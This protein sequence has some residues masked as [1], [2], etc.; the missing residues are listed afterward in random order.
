MS[1]AAPDL[2][3]KSD[4]GPRSGGG[5]LRALVVCL[6]IA[7]IAVTW[8]VGRELTALGGDLHLAGGYVLVGRFG[9]V[10]SARVLLSLAVASGVILQGPSLAARLRWPSVL[11]GSGIVAASWA[12]ALAVSSGSG[13]LAK[14]MT[15]KYDYLHDVGRVSGIGS[16]LSTF[17]GSVPASSAHPWVTH[18]AGHPPG[19]LLA[20]V[21]IDRLGLSGAGWAAAMCIAGGALAVPAVLV[22][23][24]AVADE[25]AAR[26]MAPFAVLAPAALWVATSADALF[27]GV[28]A[29]GIA[30]LA[31]AA[32]RGPGVPG[33]LRAV[34]GGLLLG[35]A[36]FLSF[37]LT[38]LG[39]VAL[40]VVLAHRQRLGRAGVIRLLAVAGLGVAVIF[41]IFA[42]GGYSWFAGIA[43]DAQ[44]VRDGAAYPDRPYAYFLVANVA[45]AAVAAGP[46]VVAGL[47]GLR[48]Q[49]LRWVPCAALGAMALSDVSGLVLGE[50]ERIWLPFV[51]FLFPATATIPLGSRRLWL[52]L[53]AV[54][55]I[56]VE[57]TVRTPW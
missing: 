21:L 15:T 18:V 36:L 17:V 31:Q 28:A 10:L 57:V 54:L 20:F 44:R 12:V 2:V 27:A 34:G 32:A 33:Y 19:A 49:R 24:R 7:G 37:G 38:A 39:L 48:R 52:A 25:A 26:A 41:A 11:V 40:A 30:L 51:V 16:F 47:A 5:R 56:V 46:A 35:M 43:V 8:L 3:R 9:V 23:V 50:T 1:T 42:A 6:V 14:P 4:V 13:R 29:W 45:A 22:T 55:A 53:S